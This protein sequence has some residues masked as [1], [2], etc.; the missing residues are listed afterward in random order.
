[1]V[2]RK[3]IADKLGVSVS[4]V[5]R[6]LN[7]SGYVD[8]EK[9]K[10]ILEAAKEMGYYR[11]PVAVS[12]ATRKTRQILFCCR[13]VENAFNIELYEGILEAAYE[14]GYTAVYSQHFGTDASHGVMMDGVILPSEGA[15]QQYLQ[16]IGKNNY[17]PAVTAAFGDGVQTPRHI[18]RVRC[19]LWHGMEM[20]LEYLRAHGHERI[21][22]ISHMPLKQGLENADGRMM[23][24]KAFMHPLLGKDVGRYFIGVTDEM[25]AQSPV[26]EQFADKR[27]KRN[28]KNRD[29]AFN[30]E[31]FFGKGQMAAQMLHESDLKPTAVVCFNDEMALGFCKQL[32]KL[33][34]RIPEDISVTG[35][36]GTFNRR[37]SDLELTTLDI[38]P[39][40]IGRKCA[41]V[42]LGMIRGEKPRSI[43][44]I[45]MD[46]IEGNTV[47]RI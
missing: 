31:D 41:E 20:I 26:Y 10:L 43:V 11:D 1:M 47:R 17:L 9:K 24:W 38:H 39:H 45:P 15:A 13:D 36:D 46:F 28:E 6:A 25:I 33:G 2:T 4:V 35:V 12:M 37:Y 34:Y 27:Y 30:A 21:A 22:M 32:R 44:D 5:S 8:A 29:L 18:P 3:D 40:L 42:L 14:Q 7:N 16:S 23:A 19:D